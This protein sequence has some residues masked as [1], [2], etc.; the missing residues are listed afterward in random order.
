MLLLLP[1]SEAGNSEAPLTKVL[2]LLLHHVQFTLGEAAELEDEAAG[3]GTLADK[4]TWRQITMD[5]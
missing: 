5:R 4:S 1:I 3:R 2:G